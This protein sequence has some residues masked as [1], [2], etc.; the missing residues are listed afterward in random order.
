MPSSI[1]ST[2]I[3]GTMRPCWLCR[4]LGYDLIELRDLRLT[5]WQS[6]DYQ[7]KCPLRA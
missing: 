4:R 3:A 6:F 7:R 2:P 1:G 5:R